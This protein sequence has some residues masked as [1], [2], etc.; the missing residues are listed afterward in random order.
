MEGGVVGLILDA[1]GRPLVLP[2]DDNQ[3]RRRLLQW[4]S[5]L[6]AYPSSAIERYG[7]DLGQST[8]ETGRKEAS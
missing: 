2:D 8:A 1:R 7:H 6:D 3:R 4:I 5:T